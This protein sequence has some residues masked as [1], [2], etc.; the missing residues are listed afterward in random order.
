MAAQKGKWMK[1]K[2]QPPLVFH[3]VHIFFRPPKKKNPYVVVP[4]FE[5]LGCTRTTPPLNN[6]VPSLIKTAILQN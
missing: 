3:S 1:S 6:V 2:L 4:Q 5:V